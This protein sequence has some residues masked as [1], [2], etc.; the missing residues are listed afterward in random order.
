MPTGLNIEEISKP[1][2]QIE[3]AYSKGKGVQ[4]RAHLTRKVI[5]LWVKCELRQ[6]DHIE[7]GLG[8]AGRML[9]TV[10]E[11]CFYME[12]IGSH[13]KPPLLLSYCHGK[14]S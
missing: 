7:R 2:E 3:H 11:L 6:R 12:I 4:T 14:T 13:W 1:G 8:K 5:P 10:T 9:R